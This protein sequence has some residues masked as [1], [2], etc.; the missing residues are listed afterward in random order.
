M[1]EESRHTDDDWQW[2]WDERLRL[3]CT[4]SNFAGELKAPSG[5]DSPMPG[6]G[7]AHLLGLGCLLG[8]PPRYVGAF[9]AAR[10][11]SARAVLPTLPLARLP[12]LLPA[13]PP[14]LRCPPFLPSSPVPSCPPYRPARSSAR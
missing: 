1:H 10:P 8:A 12:A 14:T 5:H 4:P 11:D 7:L 2:F 6:L 9:L 13:L 3:V